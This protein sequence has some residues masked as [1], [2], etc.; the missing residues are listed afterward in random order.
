[1]SVVLIGSIILGGKSFRGSYTV[2]SLGMVDYPLQIYVTVDS[3]DVIAVNNLSLGFMLDWEWKTWLDRSALRQLAQNANFRL[4]RFFDFRPTTPNL[5]PCT[6]WNETT[7]T[8]LFNWTNVDLLVQGIFEVGAEPLICI[9]N[10]YDESWI[11]VGM[12]VNPATGLPYPES[13]A[14]YSTEWV[15]HFNA[16]GLPV[17]YYEIINEP[18]LYFDDLTK[19]GYYV[20]LWNAVARSM[21]AVNPDLLLSQD[22]I[23][24]KPVLDF[25][26]QH[27]DDIDFLDS[28]KYDGNF[29]EEYSDAEMFVRAE[30]YCFETDSWFYGVEDARRMWLN[31]RGKLLPVINSE[32]NFNAA[33]KT[34]TDPR[35]QQM[36]GAVWTSLV[37]RTSILKGLSH[38]VYYSFSSGKSWQES[39]GTGFGLGMINSDDN[40]PWYPYY[41]QKLIANN[42]GVGDSIVES[43]SSSDDVR[44]LAWIHQGTLNV[45][46]IC[47]VDSPRTV[48][49][50]GLTGQITFSK[51]DNTISWETPSVQE[52]TVN[53][54]DP[55]T[56]NGYTLILLQVRM[57]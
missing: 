8:G 20:D 44:S 29:I 5:M 27:G 42:L 9:G 17:R 21:R 50:K 56:L 33:W 51:I 7:K 6:Y 12:A 11:R 18:D 14:A 2:P 34:G 46:L 22:T 30:Q 52:G 36:V 37:L 31:A 48:Y 32:Y 24:I 47:K 4:I 40:Q 38:S 25:W 45:L 28:H 19:L 15:K 49:L 43:I 26:L 55:I 16:V 53:A 13:Y 3:S 10:A 1:M 23:T 54:S 41:A 39:Y 57:T 35:I